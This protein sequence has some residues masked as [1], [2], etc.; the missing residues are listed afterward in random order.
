VPSGYEGTFIFRK[1]DDGTYAVV[2]NYGEYMT[3]YADGKTGVGGT[4]DGFAPQYENGNYNADLKFI[5]AVDKTPTSGTKDSWLGC[6]LIQGRN[7]SGDGGNNYYY[8]MAGFGSDF[9]NAQAND[10]F[11]TS[12][13][14]TSVFCLE[15]VAYPNTPELTAA[16]GLDVAAIATY[17]A[18]FATVV[19]E[20]VTA[21]YAQS[22]GGDYVSMT[23]VEGAIPANTGVVLTSETTGTVTMVPAAAEELAT[24]SGNLL[25]AAA[26]AGDCD[27]E[28]TTNAYVIGKADGV[29]AFYPLSA[30]N[31]TIAQGKSFLVLP[32]ASPV[33]KMNFGGEST[34]IETVE[35][36]DANA[37]IYDL[38]GRRVVNMT[39]GGVYIQNGK[40]FIVK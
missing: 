28:A 15:E 29:V 6:F 27:V 2:N 19:P 35:K 5:I 39:N 9:H 37:P 33:V 38:S 30:T 16:D 8:L 32:T 22:E 7:T 36:V 18:P 13:N 10:I 1:N 40:K 24:V 4:N 3:Y 11:Y 20:G 26:A 12:A 31:R 23:E 25:S 17:S 21:W 34:A 14:L